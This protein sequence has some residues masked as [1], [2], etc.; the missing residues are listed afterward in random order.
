DILEATKKIAVE[1]QEGKLSPEHITEKCFSSHLSCAD[2]PDPDL[3]I[4]TSGEQRIS[5][6]LLWQL[7]YTELYFSPKQ[8][9]DFDEAELDEALQ[10]YQARQRRFG[11][12]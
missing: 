11:G 3:F 4:R 1:V 9:P 2:L 5:N 10:T 8:W 6:F 7:A 12:L